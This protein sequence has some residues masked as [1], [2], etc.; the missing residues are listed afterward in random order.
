MSIPDQQQQSDPRASLRT[1]LLDNYLFSDDP[2]E[3]DDSQSL[4]ETGVLDST[5]ILEI[6]MFLEES[7]GIKVADDEMVPEN[8]DSVA[9]AVAFVARK[10]AEADR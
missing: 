4:L 5:G 10:V 3:L 8:L 9:A 7:F 1:F 6:V 2:D